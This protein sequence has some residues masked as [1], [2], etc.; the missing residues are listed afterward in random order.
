MKV[1]HRCTLIFVLFLL[2]VL[3]LAAEDAQTET[4][5]RAIH[6]RHLHCIRMLRKTGDLGMAAQALTQDLRRGLPPVNPCL[7]VRQPRSIWTRWKQ[8]V[9]MPHSS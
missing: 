9:L 1:L 4:L 6:E 3:T 5:A 7:A 2:P 8:V